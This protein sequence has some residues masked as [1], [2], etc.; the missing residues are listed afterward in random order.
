ME[1]RSFI[2]N[3]LASLGASP[4]V[5]RG[6]SAASAAAPAAWPRAYAF[7]RV[8]LAGFQ[9]H[10]G[11]S[12]WASLAVGQL[13]DLVRERESRTLP[14]AP[15]LGIGWRS[16]SRSAKGPWGRWCVCP[17]KPKAILVARSPRFRRSLVR[18]CRPPRLPT[19]GLTS[20]PRRPLACA[21]S[22]DPTNPSRLRPKSPR[23]LTACVD[24]GTGFR[25]LSSKRARDTATRWSRRFAPRWS[26]RV[27][28]SKR[29]RTGGFAVMR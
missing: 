18:Q 4:W 5:S 23:G 25:G 29:K 13:L 24:N 19:A 20:F 7:D 14:R 11:E 21:F 6:E 3:L 15:A 16:T 8:A 28:R 17:G 22:R 9:F 26:A 12:A 1:R 27:R 10:E 2:A